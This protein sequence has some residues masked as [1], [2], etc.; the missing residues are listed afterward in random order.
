MNNNTIYKAKN[1]DEAFKYIH[2]MKY[3]VDILASYKK[4]GTDNL[5]AYKDNRDTVREF[6]KTI[7]VVDIYMVVR[8][9]GECIYVDHAWLSEELSFYAEL[10]WLKDPVCGTKVYMSRFKAMKYAADYKRNGSYKCR[11]QIAS[12]GKKK[13]V[14]YVKKQQYIAGINM[15]EEEIR[16]ML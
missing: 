1:H 2:D 5:K 14:E 3:T 7:C 16:A 4:K 9:T 13:R 10:L 12:H 6:N 11:Y 15:S 8:E